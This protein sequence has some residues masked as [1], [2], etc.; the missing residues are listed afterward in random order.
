MTTPTIAL[1]L[2]G[3]ALALALL[4]LMR[5]SGARQELQA[6]ANDL[7]RRLA[8]QDQKWQQDR[9]FQARS[10]TRLVL[11]W[12]LRA[13]KVAA[14]DVV[15]SDEGIRANEVGVRTRIVR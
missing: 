1:L 5:A 4:A 2:A 15:E 10:L 7:R 8:N 12:N 14:S 11:H 6:E 13:D 9:E 3:I